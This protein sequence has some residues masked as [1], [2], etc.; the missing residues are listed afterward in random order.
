MEM[1]RFALRGVC[2][3]TTPSDS[4]NTAFAMAKDNIARTMR[5]YTLGWGMSNCPHASCIVVG[6]DTGWM[7]VGSDYVAPW[8]V[9][10]ALGAFRDRQRDDGAVMEYVD[11]ETGAVDDYGLDCA[12]NTPL[13]SWAL[14]HHWQMHGGEGFH[15]GFSGF[16]KRAADFMVSSIAPSGLVS[17]TAKGV[18]AWGSASWRNIIDGYV[19]AGESTEINSLFAFGL[20]QL[21]AFTGELGYSSAGEG[22][23]AAVRQRNWTG[24]AFLLT[25]HIG[26]ENRQHTGDMVFPLV[27]GIAD[28]HQ[29][30]VVIDILSN[31]AFWC[32]RGLMT[33]PRYEDEYSPTRAYGLLG[34]SWPNLTLWYAKA[35]APH[36][37]NDA[38]RALETVSASPVE[39]AYEEF[40]VRQG[41]F[42]EFF[43][44]T[45]GRNSG[46]HL[47]P[48]VAPTFIWAVLEG[49]LGLSWSGGKLA[50]SPN[51]PDGWNEV[52][53]ENIP[54]GTDMARCVDVRL[55]R[56]AAPEITYRGR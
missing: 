1:S 28:A 48:W 53:V 37:A 6:R 22:L 54:L 7:C 13:V 5:R 25:R 30:R 49:L 18:G 40:N 16:A 2:R 33:L 4:L 35:I 24:D 51:W 14:N 31:E 38:L 10:E 39:G 44:P 21:A 20:R 34:G 15:A 9:P 26:V 12:D 36:S 32:P 42:P 11:L 8:F 3:L 17:A 50:A 29:A 46:M 47:S 52:S 56:G 43:D 27:F 45:T 19:L 41:E 55:V 23:A